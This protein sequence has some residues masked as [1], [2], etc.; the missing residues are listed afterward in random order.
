MPRFQMDQQWVLDSAE[1]VAVPYGISAQ[2]LLEGSQIDDD[3]QFIKTHRIGVY[4]E[5][6][7][8][9][10][11]SASNNFKLIQKN[12]QVIVDKHTYGE[13]DAI[14]MDLSRNKQ[15]HCE[16]AVKFYLQVGAG[17]KL[18]D[19]VGPNLKDRF[20]EKYERLMHKQ[21]CFSEEPMA[22]Q[23]L[24][25]RNI[26]IDEKTVLTKGRLFYPWEHF[27]RNDFIYPKQVSNNHE[28]GFWIAYSELMELLNDEPYQWF[29]LPR[30]YWFSKVEAI[31]KE[32]LPVELDFEGFS[33][34]KIVALKEGEDGSIQEVMRGFV[35][36]DEWLYKAK[37]R[38]LD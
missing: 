38:V 33:L 4:F 8:C 12:A 7:F 37:Q 2:K 23:W 5:Q 16:L 27:I 19:W 17:D 1:L 6:L 13:F 20:D 11:I 15:I 14:L 28:K 9:H 10:L 29:Q 26:K 3:F 31:D 32:L 18:S 24:Q 36:N 21:L 30:F 25:E 34:Q 35:V 22:K